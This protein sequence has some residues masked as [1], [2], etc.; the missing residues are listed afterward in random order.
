LTACSAPPPP[1]GADAQPE[2]SGDGESS[3]AAKGRKTSKTIDWGKLN[4]LLENFALIY[5][6]DTVWDGTNRLIMKIS[7]MAHAHI[8]TSSSPAVAATVHTDPWPS[9]ANSEGALSLGFVGSLGRH[10]H[11][12][13]PTHTTH[14]RAHHRS[15]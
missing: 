3:G 11:T 14:K 5:G 7:N 9:V 13:P 15:V 2:G 8:K 4:Q 12:H 10:P 6:T 1:D